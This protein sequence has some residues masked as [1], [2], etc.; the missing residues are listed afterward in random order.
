MVPPEI[1]FA[2][3][4]CWAS[5]GPGPPLTKTTEFEVKVGAKVRKKQKQNIYCSYFVLLEE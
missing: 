2:T 4:L 1:F 3:W 5:Y